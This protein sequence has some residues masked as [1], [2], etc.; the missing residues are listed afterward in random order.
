MKRSF[1]G[2]L[3]SL[4]HNLGQVKIWSQKLLMFKVNSFSIMCSMVFVGFG[5]LLTGF[6][7]T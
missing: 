6:H 5:T 4:L 7:R 3:T 2:N 1:S